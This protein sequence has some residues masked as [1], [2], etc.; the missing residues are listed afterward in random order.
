MFSI[1]NESEIIAL[2]NGI[3]GQPA[4]A[5]ICNDWGTCIEKVL[6]WLLRLV[7]VDNYVFKS[8]PL[9]IAKR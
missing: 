8:Q 7:T 9:Q 5:T 4:T 3:N 1:E 6:A 2:Q